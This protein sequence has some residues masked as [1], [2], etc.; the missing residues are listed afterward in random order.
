MDDKQTEPASAP[1]PEETSNPTQSP[2]TQTATVPVEAVNFQSQPTPEPPQDDTKITWTAS[3]FM[4][5]TKSAS[6]YLGLFLV[7]IIAAAGFYALFRDLITTVVI[8]IA[9]AALGFYASRK[10]RQLEY[11]LDSSGLSIADKHFL[12]SSFRSFSLVDEGPFGSIAFLPMKRFG[13]LITVYFAPQDEERIVNL[14]GKHLPLEPRSQDA[15]DK[16]MTRIRF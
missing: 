8:L 2:A 13:L 10:P 12:Y 3:E 6:W 9:A 16:F 1:T 11:Q 7:A 15:I 4:D 5:H 14:I